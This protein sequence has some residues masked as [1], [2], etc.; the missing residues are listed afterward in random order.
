MKD[1]RID[2]LADIIVNYS[3]KLKSGEKVLIEAFDGPEMLTLSVLRKA[4]EKGAIPLVSWRN[5]RILRDLYRHATEESMKLIGAIEKYR[6]KRMDAYVG[7]RSSENITEFSDVPDKKMKL[8]QKYWLKPVHLELR[9]AKTRWVVMRYPLPSM[10]Q[11]AGM[12]TEAFED[13]YFDVC[14]VDYEKMSRAMEPLKKRM[15]TTDKVHIVGPGT[16]LHFSKKDI[17]VLK[18]DGTA[19]LP[20]GE[21]FTAPVKDSVNGIISYNTPSLYHGFVFENI[22]LEFKKGAILKA[23]ANNTEKINALLNSDKGARYIGEFALGVNP[24]IT[25]PM[26]DTLFDE[27]IAGSFHFTPGAAYDETDNGNRSE[28]HWDLVCI[29]TTEYGGGEI[30]FDGE[31]IRKNGLFVPEDLQGLNPE[32]LAAE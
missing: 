6:M 18:G 25:R 3:L 15:E 20:D 1:P 5:N 2:R 27:K 32:N 26:K 21:I 24:K 13:F 22:R 17:P 14:T 30:Y 4:A 29:Q 28:I 9:V 19:N 11:Q 16:D 31:L 8:Y 10:A 23:E 7:I 12:S